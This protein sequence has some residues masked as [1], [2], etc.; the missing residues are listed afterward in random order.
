MTEE[1]LNEEM[2]ILKTLGIEKVSHPEASIGFAK[3]NQSWY[4]WS[5]RAINGFKVGSRVKM[6]DIAFHASNKEEFAEQ[7][8]RF[9][10]DSKYHFDKKVE[11]KSNGVE[12]SATYNDT[13][14]NKDL[15]GTR[16]VHFEKYPKKWGKGEWTAKT[17][18]DAKQMAI[19]FSKGL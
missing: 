9:W 7:Q 16:Y 6:G 4:G 3:K 19:D 13:V 14:P 5:H 15:R 8:K 11:M 18:D 17:L 1:E 10:L 12:V 2:K